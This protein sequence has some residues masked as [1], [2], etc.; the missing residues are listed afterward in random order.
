MKRIYSLLTLLLLV[1]SCDI[2][3][4]DPLTSLDAD[5]ALVDGASANGVLLGAYSSMQ[6][7]YYYG[8]EYVCN[9]DLLAD[10]AVFEGFF[11]SQL[12]LDSK[13]VPF[14]NLFVTEAWVQIY[15]VINITNLLI[16]RVPEIDDPNFGNADQVLGEAYGLRAL[17]Y[18]DLLRYF[19]EFY[20]ESSQFGLPLLLEPIP[21]ND[22]TQIPDLSRS[23]VAE[24]YTQITND[25]GQA[26]DLLQGTSDPERMNYWAALSLRA[27]I[28]LYRG[29]YAQA[30]TDANDV[31]ENGGYALVENLEELYVT[32]P[33]SESIFEVA[34]ND[35]D[36]S[37]YNSFL[38]RR[39]EYNVDGSLL[40]AFEDGDARASLFIFS[41]NQDRCNKYPDPTNA[42]NAKVFRLAELYLIRAE[43]AAMD[44]NDPNAGLDDLNVIRNRAGLPDLDPFADMDGFVAALMQERR[45]ELSFEGHRFFDLVRMDMEEEIGITEEFRKILPIPRTELQVQENLAQN[46]GYETL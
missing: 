23:T 30:F 16:A 38:I 28:A 2:L 27:R 5:G 10:N 18:F 26:L 24:T 39:D 34:F 6:D 21:D 40:D 13:S 42:D 35:Q 15:R 29:N 46:P 19:G 32:D 22:F 36:Q 12:E 14:S 33:T 45:I 1:A 43:A 25:L 41:R 37:A 17:A 44:N 31:I 7:D 11:D 4:P 8:L 9:N 3:E 20:D